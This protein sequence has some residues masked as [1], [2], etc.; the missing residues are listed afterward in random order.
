[1]RYEETGLFDV[2]DEKPT[3]HASFLSDATQ[4]VC[5]RVKLVPS[6]LESL[7]K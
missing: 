1:M 4:C 2:K 5:E 7:Y 3:A 6:I